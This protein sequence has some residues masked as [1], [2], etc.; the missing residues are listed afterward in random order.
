MRNSAISPKKGR[1]STN[2]L[3]DRTLDHLL[4]LRRRRLGLEIRARSTVGSRT[5]PSRPETPSLPGGPHRERAGAA[6]ATSPRL[7]CRRSSPGRSWVVVPGPDLRRDRHQYRRRLSGP[8]RAV[9]PP[10]NGDLVPRRRRGGGPAEVGLRSADDGP[11]GVDPAP[12]PVGGRD[13]MSAIRTVR[14]AG[15]R[16]RARSSC[17]KPGGCPSVRRDCPHAL[18]RS[19]ETSAGPTWDPRR[20]DVAFARAALLILGRARDASAATISVGLIGATD[21]ILVVLGGEKRVGTDC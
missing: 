15:W 21:D 3:S 2:E 19:M 14:T 8:P 20:V 16:Y 17:S 5:G 18:S 13:Y 1:S 9:R 12:A 4:D 11:G 7:R 10:R 6:G